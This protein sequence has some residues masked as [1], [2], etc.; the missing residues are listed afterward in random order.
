MEII[1]KIFYKEVDDESFQG[2]STKK[3][4]QKI[5]VLKSFYTQVVN[6]GTTRIVYSCDM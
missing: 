5:F 6:Y 3:K 4:G 2:A 1:L